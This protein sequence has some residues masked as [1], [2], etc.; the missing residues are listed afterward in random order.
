MFRGATSIHLDDKG[1]MAIPARYRTE[2]IEQHD[3]Q[4]ICTLDVRHPCLLLYGQS[5]WEKI[6]SKLAKLSDFDP[7]QSRLKRVILGFAT[8][9]GLDKSG[10]ILL[11]QELRERINLDKQI[12]LVGQLNKFEIWSKAT[13]D[14]QISND[15]LYGAKGDFANVE[16]FQHFSL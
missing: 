5:D 12:M 2:I 11:S 6:E 7:M 14:E 15:L 8:D 4:M 3:G 13:W 1:R 16:I 9:V 10:R